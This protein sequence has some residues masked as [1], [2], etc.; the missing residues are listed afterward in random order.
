MAAAKLSDLKQQAAQGSNSSSFNAISKVVEKHAGRE[1]LLCRYHVGKSL[2]ADYDV[3]DKVLGKGLNGG[4]RLAIRRDLPSQCVAVKRLNL[5]NVSSRK[6]DNILSEVAIHL[7][8]DHPHI[9]SLFDVYEFQDKLELALECLDGGELFDRIEQC[10]RLDE[11]MAANTTRQLLSAINHMHL[12]GIAHRDLKLENIV[13]ASRSGRALDHLKLIDFGFSKFRRSR[14]QK[15]KT[16]CGTLSYLAPEVL[17]REYT[18]QCDI[19]SLGVIVYIMLSGQMPFYGPDKEQIENIKHGNYAMK[20]HRWTKISPEAITFVQALMNTDP[21]KRLTAQQSLQHPWLV[22]C[23][24]IA[25]V[26]I[27]SSVI[28]ALCVHQMGPK[29]RRCCRKLLARML[30]VEYQAKSYD[31]FVCLDNSH[32]GSIPLG[33]WLKDFPELDADEKL[34]Q[35]IQAIGSDIISTCIDYSDFLAAL[36]LSELDVTSKMLD[37]TFKKFEEQGGGK[38]TWSQLYDSVG[39]T[40]ED[41][42]AN[43]FADVSDANKDGIVSLSDFRECVCG[44]RAAP[45]KLPLRLPAFSN[46]SPKGC[47]SPRTPA[48]TPGTLPVRRYAN[49]RASCRGIFDVTSPSMASDSTPMSVAT[50]SSG[51]SPAT[52]GNDKSPMTFGDYCNDNVRAACRGGDG[53]AISPN[54]ISP[55]YPHL[56]SQG[57]RWQPGIDNNP[58][59]GSIAELHNSCQKKVGRSAAHWQ[60]AMDSPKDQPGH[61]AQEPCT[62]NLM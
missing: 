10:H 25:K 8:M 6:R 5:A 32:T 40:R 38:I 1:A 21:E 26:D 29:F 37:S 61:P 53:T 24:P 35:A 16:D 50:L 19:W 17:E 43:A 27:S 31:L 33:Q 9:V 55:K 58:P 54:S 22:R 23:S 52:R 3:S 44:A 2:D 60:V 46:K 7:C 34:C 14:D 11:K 36:M 57:H 45:P 48:M 59:F 12:H 15:M 39:E 49:V 30:P 28:R 51:M 13:F 56:L 41:L 18:N 20:P 47:A 62:C 42:K 4:V